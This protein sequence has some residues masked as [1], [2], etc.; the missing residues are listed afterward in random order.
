MIRAVIFDMF[1]TLVTL[2]QGRTYFSENIAEDLGIPC[3]EFRDAWHA[4]E[5]E[6]TIG[7]MTME[8]G[9]GESLRKIGRYSD[10]A[11]EM[12]CRKRREALGDTF[13]AV[14]EESVR[15]LR[16]LR[17]HGIRT[18]LISNCFS[19]EREMILGS[20][21]Y[22]LF[23]TVRLS[24]EQGVKK[25]DP[26]MYQSIMDEFGVTPAECLYVG[27]GGSK[28]LFAARALGMT[29]V[30]ALWFRPGMFEPHV[31]S[32]VYTEFAHMET[33]ADVLTEAL[34]INYEVTDYITPEEY[35]QMRRLVGWSEFPLEQ[36]AEGLGHSSYLCCFRRGGEPIAMTRVIWDHGYVVYLADVIVRPDCQANGLGRDLM[37][38][39][40]AFIGSNLKPGY[41][42]MVSLQAAKGK[43]E[44]Y[45][46]FG[47]APRPTDEHG[48]GMHQWLEA[49]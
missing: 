42:V 32:P 46:R 18:G 22:P 11:V 34:R 30:Q 5:V 9:L 41:R 44:F 49:K 37:N 13:A 31:P 26:V 8:E 2:F 47:F 38:R 10:E 20:V 45:E 12:V 25:P 27:D 39:V 4:T 14:P 6:R 7:T 33:Q 43:E 16:V 15:L 28:E 3:K 23:D 40:M 17:A 36:A 21:L 24:Y 19:D 35:M 48:C 1:E 29:A